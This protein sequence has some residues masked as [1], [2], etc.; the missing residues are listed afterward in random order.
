MKIIQRDG[1]IYAIHDSLDALKKDS[2]WYGE[3]KEG[4]QVSRM[5]HDKGKVVKAHSHKFHP[6]SLDHTQE[7]LIV[8][9]GKIEFSFYDENKVFFDKI[10]LNPGDLVVVYRGYHG[11][12]VI[13]DDT[14]YF[15]IKTGP[16][17][18]I[19]SDKEFID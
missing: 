18:D 16:F 14:L 4:I 5:Y 10:I 3:N 7:C 2:L 6:R 17:T 19:E 12:E 11:M 13:E 1:V 8:F 9:K 15:E